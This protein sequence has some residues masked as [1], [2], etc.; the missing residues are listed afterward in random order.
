MGICTRMLGNFCAHN[1]PAF[2]EQ[3]IELI[4]LLEQNERES[5]CALGGWILK[6]ARSLLLIFLGFISFY[7]FFGLL[8]LVGG[9]DLNAV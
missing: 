1:Y 3:A 6:E 8:K 2:L 5:F 4:D 7:K 9:I